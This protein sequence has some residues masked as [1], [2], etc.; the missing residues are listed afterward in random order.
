MIHSWA[1]APGRLQSYGPRF[2]SRKRLIHR[3]V[4]AIRPRRTLD[5]GCG[6]G[7]IT[8]VLA[9][10]S[11]EVVAVDVSEQAARVSRGNLGKATNVLLKVVDVFQSRDAICDWSGS[12]DL[13]VLSEV[14]E[15]IQDDDSALDTVRQL[16]GER[17]W[18]L[19]SVPG[20]P[21]LW[22]AEDE[23]AGHVRRYTREELRHKL[24][25]HGFKIVRM[26]NWGFPVTRW[27]YLLEVRLFLRGRPSQTH[28]NG[29]R[30]RGHWL[31]LPLLALTRPLFAAIADLE[32][33]ISGLDRGV[34]YVVLARKGATQQES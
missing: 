20:D 17:G 23:Q 11:T 6:S 12:F 21:K 10:A 9:K 15:H 13:V 14:L 1:G 24:T 4:K 3:L 28:G 22:N 5:I 25:K 34:G 18:L 31:L 19:T 2:I 29:H 30:P 16:L 33:L 32:S 27:L 8:K 26:I 7:L